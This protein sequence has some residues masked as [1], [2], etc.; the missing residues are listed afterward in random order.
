MN[1]VFKIGIDLLA[2]YLPVVPVTQLLFG[3][4]EA[5]RTIHIPNHHARTFLNQQKF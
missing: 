4:D 5:H 3:I 1:E 2:V